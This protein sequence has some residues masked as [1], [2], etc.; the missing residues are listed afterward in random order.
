MQAV[1]NL[2]A[3]KAGWS[4]KAPAG[5]FRGMAFHNSFDSPDCT[6]MEVSVRGGKRVKINRVVR[7]IDHGLS[8]NPDQINSQFQSGLV[9]GLTT[10]M[11]SELNIKAGAVVQSNFNNYNL[12]RISQMPKFEVYSVKNQNS[13][14]GIGEPVYH[15]VMPALMNALSAA[16]GKRVRSLP[17]KNPGFSL[18]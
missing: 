13:P 10:A 15:S 9:W 3:E 7:A 4:K 1:L 16:T 12:L 11:Y 2:A 18:A 6:I 5:V 17:L 8:V 14:S